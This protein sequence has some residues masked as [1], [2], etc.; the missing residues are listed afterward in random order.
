ML[1]TTNCLLAVHNYY[2]PRGGAE[3]LFLEHNRL[4]E[5]IGWQVVPFATKHANNVPTPWADYFPDELELGGSYS[6]G[7]KLLRAQ[8]VIYSLQARHKLRDLLDNVRPQIAH[9][10]STTCASRVSDG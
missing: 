8:R 5:E 4:F 2:Y 7:G 3:V 9:R 6:L 10:L 1:R